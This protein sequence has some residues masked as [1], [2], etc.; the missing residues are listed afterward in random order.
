M[1]VD[2]VLELARHGYPVI[3]LRPASKVPAIDKWPERATT[4]LDIIAD[5]FTDPDTGV[6]IATGH[7]MR[8][9]LYHVVIDVDEHDPAASGS[10]AL[11]DLETELG[12]LPDTLTTITPTGGLHYHYVAPVALTNAAGSNL[13]TGLDIRGV[14]GYV[15]APP[16]IHPDGGAYEWEADKAL[17]YV[18]DELPAAWVARLAYVEE[19][20]PAPPA[21]PAPARGLFAGPERPGDAWA[22]AHTWEQ[23]LTADQWQ[24]DGASGDGG[25]AWIR[26]GK[27]RRDGMGATVGYK[28]S[29][30]LKVFTSSAPPLQ[31]DETYTK[32]GYL[33][34]TKYGGDYTATVDALRGLGYGT[35]APSSSPQVVEEAVYEAVDV[36]EA[37]EAPIPLGDGQNVPE[38]PVGIFPSW[39]ADHVRQVAKEMQLTPDP[40]CQLAVTALS[41]VTAGRVEILVDGERT[42]PTNTYSVTSLP[43]SAGKSPSVGYMLAPLDRWEEEL[44]ELSEKDIGDRN[45][46]RKI[47]EK[48]RDGFINKGETAAAM[49]EQD[50]LYE[51][52][53]IKPPRLLADDAT[54]EK[55]VEL[56]AEQNGRLALVSTEGGLFGMMVGR[57]SDKSNLDVYLGAWSR[58]TIRRDRIDRGTTVVR[59]P[60]LTIGLTVQPEVLTSLA[61]NPELAG[62]GLTARFMYAVPPDN[63]GLRDRRRR[64]SIDRHVSARYADQLL[65]IAR[66]LDAQDGD[67]VRLELADD[68]IDL[69]LD[70]QQKHEDRIGPTGDYRHIAEWLAK[71][72]STVIRLAAM[73]H[74]ADEPGDRSPV[75]AATVARAIQAGDYWTVHALA[76]HDLMGADETIGKARRIIEWLGDHG[77]DEVTVRD[78]QQP[79]RRRFPRAADIVPVIELL[80]ERGWLRPLDDGPIAAG[81]GG[82][83]PRLAVHPSVLPRPHRTHTD[84]DSDQT[85]TDSGYG[86]TVSTVS[87]KEKSEDLL[88]YTEPLDT[89]PPDTRA[90]CPQ[91]STSSSPTTTTTRPATPTAAH[92]IPCPF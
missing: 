36:G 22:D 60:T 28:G 8:P 63:V 74:L 91:P 40:A 32:L 43:P 56:L 69:L 4:D 20:P 47:R 5:W 45:I 12:A 86:S 80:V 52:P 59:R 34:V 10:E 39:I 90:H 15:V 51:L 53:E 71:C 31:A 50:A 87:Y 72:E 92:G 2:D 37:W 65:Y 6:G 55:L 23:I 29:D 11:A 78:I 33:A 48:A 81:R 26:P 77:A 57:Y 18:L 67:M 61:D 1:T 58:D 42:E 35:P 79:L 89:R 73:L 17:D 14:G 41:V 30:I 46:E 68:A 16:S 82:K 66:M 44:A 27:A 70:W 9:G 7:E 19:R 3:P 76:A 88:T 38:W 62:R 54:P 75:P 24:H 49:A 13:P 84:A 25:E 83:S 85:A 64:S 21:R